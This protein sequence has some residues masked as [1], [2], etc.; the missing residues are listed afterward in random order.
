MEASSTKS[1]TI[2]LTTTIAEP[3]GEPSTKE[4]LRNKAFMFLFAAQFSQNIGAAVSWL[5]LQFF[6][7]SMTGSPGL[8]GLLSI[9]Y[10]LPYVLITPFAGVLVDRFDQRKIMLVSN[11]LSFIASLGYVLVYLLREKLIIHTITTIFFSNGGKTI[12]HQFNTIH[13]IWLLFVFVFFNQTAAAFFFPS[14]NAY[15]RLVVQKK[16]LLI[17]NSIGTT[18][19]QVATIVGYVL[20]GL[21]ASINYLASFIFDSS[22]FAFSI[23]MIILIMLF[24][25]KPPSPE[26][27]KAPNIKKEIESVKD[28]LI[29]GYRTI[30]K[31]PKVSY[32]LI[33]FA[34]AI[35]S[36][37]AFNVLF[38]VI[39]QGEMGLNSTWYGALQAVM[40]TSGIVTALILM[41]IGQLD[42]KIL[43]LN[44]SI[45]SLTVILYFYSFIRNK[46]AMIGILF[47]LG[48]GLVC[49]NIPATTLIQELIPYE[50]QGRVFG[51]QQ[52]IQGIARLLGMGLV[53]LIAEIVLPMYI[54]LASS[55]FMTIVVVW[56]FFYSSKRGLMKS[57]YCKLEEEDKELEKAK[58]PSEKSQDKSLSINQQEEIIQSDGSSS[59]SE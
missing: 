27:E 49:I 9:I 52:L 37:A 14:R 35:F 48:I 11:I 42:R 51:T 22:T 44:I 56:G 33:L 15:T 58:P 12:I 40:G 7:F 17:A 43:I 3:C 23:S 6:I 26:R 5:A 19:F 16:N 32:M 10:W 38:I 47:I 25:Q 31:T 18:V 30:R 29:I 13:I 45:S 59:Y 24:G 57:D 55:V 2:S 39:L 1:E 41:N 53:S 34:S 21:L 8:M 4:V 54:I 50:K 46:W 36:F 20:A 28:D